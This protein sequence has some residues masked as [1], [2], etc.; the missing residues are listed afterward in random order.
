MQIQEVINHIAAGDSV[1]AKES[2]EN[3]LSAK[4][5]D[6]LQTRKQEIA[7]TLFG[8]Q[9]QEQEQEYEE[10]MEEGIKGAAIGGAL[11]SVGGPV[12]A[13]VGG[14]L[15]H[16]AGEGLASLRKRTVSAGKAFA[17]K[18]SRD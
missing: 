9:E 4:A 16:V 1:A 11:G 17:T 5:F 10:A 7:S 15:G 12:G 2:I 18:P 13:A 8:G 3:I 14:A 6:A